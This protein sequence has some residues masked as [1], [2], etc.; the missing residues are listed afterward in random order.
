MLGV[1]E[2]AK[3]HFRVASEG[4]AF[5]RAH[6]AKVAKAHLPKLQQGLAA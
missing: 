4:R 5:A 1:P 6:K 2:V 3:V